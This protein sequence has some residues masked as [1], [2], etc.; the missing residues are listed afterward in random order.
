[1]NSARKASGLS[2]NKAASPVQL[3]I[4]AAMLPLLHVFMPARSEGFPP[5]GI[6]DFFLNSEKLYDSV[7]RYIHCI[8]RII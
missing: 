6:K 1:V 7:L 3:K 2:L 4:I 5:I 8:W